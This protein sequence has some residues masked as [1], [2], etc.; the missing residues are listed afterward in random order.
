MMSRMPS[1]SAS[2]RNGR[3]C[4]RLGDV[5][6]GEGSS[7]QEASDDLIRRLLGLVVALRASG[8][9]A[10]GEIRIDLETMDFLFALGEFAAAGGDI[11]TRVFG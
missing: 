8:F 6:W 9:T 11:R 2:E 10:S 4:L 7:L 5:A 1:L 3:V